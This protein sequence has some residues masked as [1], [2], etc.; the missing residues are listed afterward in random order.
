MTLSDLLQ[1]LHDQRAERARELA[2]I[3]G[4]IERLESVT[5]GSEPTREARKHEAK[6]G[7][8]AAPRKAKAPKPEPTAK[9]AKLPKAT[10]AK[11]VPEPPANATAPV[12]HRG[13]VPFA[14]GVMRLDFASRDEAIG[15][16]RRLND[17]GYSRERQRPL[18]PGTFD[19]LTRGDG[20]VLVWVE[21]PSDDT[22]AA[23]EVAA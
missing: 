1:Q 3:D 11:A 20:F 19:L 9:P 16:A 6:A 12:D 5:G 21:R 17:R 7:R 2:A 22:H 18:S 10:A 8:T 13:R 23:R 4:A 14:K 15:A